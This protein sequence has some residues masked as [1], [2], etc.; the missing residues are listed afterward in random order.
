MGD[1]GA[2]TTYISSFTPGAGWVQAARVAAEVVTPRN[3]ATAAPGTPGAGSRAAPGDAAPGCCAG[4]DAPSGGRPA[5]ARRGGPAAGPGSLGR[6]GGG[7]DLAEER[8]GGW[9]EAGDS[10]EQRAVSRPGETV[11]GAHGGHARGPARIQVGIPD[12]F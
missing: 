4:S 11:E 6:G 12:T 8:R 5:G 3:R 2:E 9:P 10:P 1:V 7:A